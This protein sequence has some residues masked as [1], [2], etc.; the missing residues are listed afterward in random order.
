MNKIVNWASKCLIFQTRLLFQII[1]DIDGILTWATTFWIKT[2]PI[3]GQCKQRG[4]CCNN[5]AIGIHTHINNRKLLVSI[6]NWWYTFV[7]RFTLKG[8]YK[9]EQIWLY[10]CQY[11]K[12]NK[13]SIYWRRPLLCRR[14]PK[15]LRKTDPVTFMPGCGYKAHQASSEGL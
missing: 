7:Y 13:C 6:A 4:V 8:W 9:K 5:I 14:Y 15:P 2:T 3:E 1:R 10:K 12:N 11:L